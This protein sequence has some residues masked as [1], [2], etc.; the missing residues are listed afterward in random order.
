M[1]PKAQAF[2]TMAM[3]EL[4]HPLW[5]SAA[6]FEERIAAL[7]GACGDDLEAA[8][9][10]I[11]AASRYEKAGVQNRAANLFRAALAGPQREVTRKEVLGMLAGCLARL[12]ES[13][14]TGRNRKAVSAS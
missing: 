9:H 5:A 10:R 6:G 12:K 8:V 13:A 3:A 2:G 1:L 7:L 4:V 11:S 14:S